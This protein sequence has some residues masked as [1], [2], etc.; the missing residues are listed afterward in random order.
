MLFALGIILLFLGFYLMFSKRTVAPYFPTKKK[1]LERINNLAKL[2]SGM[3]FYDL[4]CGDGRVCLYLAK[5]NPNI[6]VLGIESSYIF[7]SIAKIRA[8]LAQLPNLTIKLGDVFQE[9]L[10][11]ADCLY[12]F[13]FTDTI[14]G[15]LKKK[16]LEEMKPSSKLIS[17]AFRINDWPGIEEVHGKGISQVKILIYRK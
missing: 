6:N 5:K 3:S 13:A 4:G 11:G 16:I 15:K 9:N 14:N 10:G 2:G 7:Y 12:T 1:D 8:W 17:Y